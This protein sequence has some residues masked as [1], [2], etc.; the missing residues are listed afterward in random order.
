MVYI[1]ISNAKNNFNIQIHDDYRAIQ[2]E[3][4]RTAIMAELHWTAM[5]AVKCVVYNFY[6]PSTFR[7]GTFLKARSALLIVSSL[8]LYV[9]F[10]MYTLYYRGRSRK[11]KT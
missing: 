7:S 1:N 2:S 10:N 5:I 11:S 6:K 3:K 8:E 9:S 4:N